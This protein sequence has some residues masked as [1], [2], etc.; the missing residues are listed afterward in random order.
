M[1]DSYSKSGGYV[2]YSTCSIMVAEVRFSVATCIHVYMLTFSC[3]MF[4]I[5]FLL[6]IIQNEAVIDYVLKRRDVKLVPCGL[7]FGR[8]G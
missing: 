4:L 6:K 5:I 1:V 2:V 8:P 7:D 3:L